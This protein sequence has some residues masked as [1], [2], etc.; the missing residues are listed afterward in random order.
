[1]F[2]D[3]EAAYDGLPDGVKDRVDGLTAVHDFGNFREGLR[4]RGATEEQIAEFNA[5]YPNPE[6]PV[7]RTHPET[8]RRSIYVNA[9]FTKRIVGMNADESTQLLSLL[10]RQAHLPEYQCR[11]RWQQ[12]S[13]AFW[14]NRSSQHY[15][16]SDYWPMTRTAERVTIVGDK[17]YFDPTSSREIPADR[18]FRGHVESLRAGKTVLY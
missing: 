11:F 12:H 2:A 10:F 6:H 5:K 9:A 15:A 13:V 1:L 7:I 16:V 3:M 17:P 8:G 18:P 4:K 14:D